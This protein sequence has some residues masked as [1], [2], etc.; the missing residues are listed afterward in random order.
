METKK[1]YL[2]FLG[3]GNVTLKWK[4][5]ISFIFDVKLGVWSLRG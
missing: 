2:D 3:S 5:L 1:D 4:C